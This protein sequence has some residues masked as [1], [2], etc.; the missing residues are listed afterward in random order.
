M[1]EHFPSDSSGLLITYMVASELSDSFVL[2][3][4][5]VVMTVSLNK[6]S[7]IRESV[8]PLRDTIPPRD[9]GDLGN[10]AFEV[11]F[12]HE[13]LIAK[14]EKEAPLTVGKVQKPLVH[15]VVSTFV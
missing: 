15:L 11:T 9:H 8:S 4:V 2:A 10:K 1:P 5:R 13:W 3:S 6:L 12:S 7:L 14:V